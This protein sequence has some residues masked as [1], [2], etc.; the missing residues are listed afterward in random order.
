MSV[1]YRRRRLFFIS[2]IAMIIIIYFAKNPSQNSISASDDL[3]DQQLKPDAE[4]IP[5]KIIPEIIPTTIKVSEVQSRKIREEI[6]EINGKKLRKIDWH[7]Y[8]S[9]AR[10]NARTGTDCLVPYFSIFYCFVIN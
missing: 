9:I 1:R 6:V 2:V 4:P 7:D 8:E 3:S 5:N 10:D